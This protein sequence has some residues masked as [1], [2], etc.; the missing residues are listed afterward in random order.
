MTSKNMLSS[1]LAASEGL[2][3]PLFHEL[4][5]TEHGFSAELARSGQTT[6]SFTKKSTKG[7]DQ[8]S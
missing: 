2:D 1:P 3:Q 4:G 6:H 8:R 7:W 5:A